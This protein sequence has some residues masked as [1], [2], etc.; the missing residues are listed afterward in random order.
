MPRQASP[1][2]PCGFET[3]WA[4]VV[5]LPPTC[6]ARAYPC[7]GPCAVFFGASVLLAHRHGRIS[8]GRVKR[9]VDAQLLASRKARVA[10]PA[11]L[12]RPIIAK[13]GTLPESSLQGFP[14]RVLEIIPGDL[15][16]IRTY[17]QSRSV[18][19]KCRPDTSSNSGHIRQQLATM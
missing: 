13:G 7:E 14:L 12:Q 16:E 2:S 15:G 19:A 5:L 6:R 18:L 8:Q 11:A 1:R 9:Q 3:C 4:T 10:V 17:P